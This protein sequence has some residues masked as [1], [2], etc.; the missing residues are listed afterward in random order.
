LG[1]DFKVFSVELDMAT[2]LLR[3][4][5]PVNEAL[6]RVASI[7]PSPTLRDL[8]IS[9]S[10]I[11]S[12]GG[13]VAQVVWSLVD[14]YVTRYSIRVERSV[15]ALNMFM[16]VYVAVALLIPILVGSTAALLIIYPLAG[17]SFEALMVL[18]TLILV[19]VSS[20]AI[21]VLADVIVS[22]VRP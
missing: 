5:V 22:R 12:I 21:V 3:V 9:L 7:T 13:G 11:A 16:E 18:T 14:R 19:P 15:E 20:A 10:S 6:K 4:G 17:I 1:K 8:F 2:S